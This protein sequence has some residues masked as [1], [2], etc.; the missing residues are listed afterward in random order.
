MSGL[1][2]N[3]D[4]AIRKE[5]TAQAAW[6][7]ITNTFKIGDYGFF[8]G[9]VFR[10]IGNIKDKYPDITLESEDGPSSKINFTSDGTKTIKFDAQGN[11]VNSFA[12]LGN[13]DAS[14][15]FSFN[16][17][18]SSVIKANITSSQLKNIEE[19]A[20][21][22]AGKDSW[23][24]KF[25]VVSSVYKASNCVIICSREAGT[26]FSIGAKANVLKEIEIGEVS[27]GFEINSSRD[28]VFETI[29][30]SGIIALR[31]FQLG[32]LNGIK[33]MKE[34]TPST[35]NVL[36]EKEFSEAIE[37]DF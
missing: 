27:G 7:P 33:L 5:L 10:S 8:E 37:D 1:A 14:L 24:K 34:R 9:G 19:V 31:L 36:I 16:E 21:K 23:K 35:S 32:W 18:N 12:A 30:E 6:F 4:K 11:V 29:G 22:L 13:A 2:K 20:I 26:E 17:A 28:S 15:R 3:F 25:K